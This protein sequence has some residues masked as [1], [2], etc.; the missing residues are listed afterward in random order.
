MAD[1]TE[2][3]RWFDEARQGDPVAMSKLLACHFPM[4]R[5]HVATRM[6][7]ALMARMEPE[8]ILQEV[9]LDAQRQMGRLRDCGEDALLNWLLTIAD[10]KLIDAR[11]ALHRRKRDIDREVR[12]HLTGSARSYLNLLDQVYADSM[13]PSRIV[14]RQEGM[15][16]LMA[17]LS[18]LSDDHR[19]V[20]QLRFLEGMSMSDVAERL[21][22]TEAAV[23]ALTKRALIEL[24]E[25]MDGMGEFTRIP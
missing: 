8:D 6:E 18:R 23:V 1:R 21:G 4:L 2:R 24:R 14:R 10:S 19:E 13:T 25:R 11:R 12:P 3:Q 5:A 22:R 20:L 16:A 9:F 17:C 15:G 7:R